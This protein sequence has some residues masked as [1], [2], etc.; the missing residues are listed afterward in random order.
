MTP[1][2]LQQLIASNARA[3]AA[4]ADQQSALTAKLNLL[5]EQQLQMVAAI[6]RSAE[7]HDAATAERQEFRQAMMGLANLL[8]AIDETRP[9]V[10]QK[11]NRIED[12]VDRLLQ[13]NDEQ[14]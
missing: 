9:T 6:N 2:E 14:T 4:L 8:S 13:Q 10:L 5:T 3:I 7:L 11:L 1:E 12:K